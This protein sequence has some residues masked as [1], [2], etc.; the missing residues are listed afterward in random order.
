LRESFLAFGRRSMAEEKNSHPQEP[1]A[2]RETKPRLTS[3]VVLGSTLAPLR[4]RVS[5]QLRFR[6]ATHKSFNQLANLPILPG[7]HGPFRGESI[8]PLFSETNAARKPWQLPQGRIVSVVINTNHSATRANNNLAAS[9]QLLQKSLNR[10]SSGS[11]IVSPADDAGGL[12]VSMKLSAA[13]RRQGATN[14][15]LSNAVSLLQTQDGVLSVTGKILSRISELKTLSSDITKSSSDKANYQTEF[16]ALQAQLT[17]NA[18]EQF[19]GISLFGSIDRSVA[20][21]ENASAT[22]MIELKA[23]NLLASLGMVSSQWSASDPDVDMNY[24]IGS[25]G[26]Y[27]SAGETSIGFHNTSAATYSSNDSVGPGFTLTFDT[28]TNGSSNYSGMTLTAGGSTINLTTLLGAGSADHHVVIADDGTNTTVTIDGSLVS[29][30]ASIATSGGAPLTFSNDGSYGSGDFHIAHLSLVGGSM[31][32]GPTNVAAVASA[33][34]LSSLNL[35]TI[36]SAIQDIA[37]FRAENGATQSRLGYASESLEVN[38]ANLEAAISR[39]A[40]VDVALESTT[41][42]RANILVQAGTA[43]LSQANQSS[44]MALRLL[45]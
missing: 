23:I 14:T 43:M 10:L 13:S 12:A 7:L 32:S 30:V 34:D 17:A 19:N 36:T 31:S 25:G 22:G 8:S 39:I 44:Q 16:A 26:A 27:V 5:T 37:T 18:G 28:N 1:S 15:N 42:A 20:G 41:L 33:T 38:Q 45:S 3:A 2:G 29:T 4:L 40:D 11:R 24:I 6:A 21:T 35:T 9:N